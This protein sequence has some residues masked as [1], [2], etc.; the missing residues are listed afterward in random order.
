MC[1]HAVTNAVCGHF[2]F[3]QTTYVMRK[4]AL[5][6]FSFCL[7]AGV[8]AQD[9]GKKSKRSKRKNLPASPVK[10]TKGGAINLYVNQGGFDNWIHTG[11]ANYS[12]GV[13]GY[14]NLF[15]NKEWKGKRK[16]REKNWSTNLDVLQAIQSIH[17]ERTDENNFS[18]LEDRLDFQTRYAINLHKKFYLA[19][20][21]NLRTQL[22]DSKNE[23][24]KRISGFFAPAYVIA[25]PVGV[26]W[27][28][29]EGFQAFV[30][31]ASLR[32][33]FVTNGPYS[34]S[35]NNFENAKPYGV[36]PGKEVDFQPGAYAQ[37]NLNKKLAKN[38]KLRSRLDVY[39][40]YRNNPD[41]PDIYFTNFLHMS[42]NK[43][44]SVGINLDMIYDDDI[45][46]FGWDHTKPAL[47]YKHILGVGVSAKF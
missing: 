36:D 46:H 47:Q 8:M 29:C 22:Y 32:W 38:I 30:T 34:I 39:S 9:S 19:G 35:I 23:D 16:G 4:V 12:L 7:A 27:R 37:F 17:N 33:V 31:P 41:N 44:I 3:N 13:N 45:R 40:N 21:A 42:V 11:N 25:A 6:I 5:L 28:P 20:I 43:W 26:E 1:P 18:K 2:I 10:W 15:A 14:L 24:G